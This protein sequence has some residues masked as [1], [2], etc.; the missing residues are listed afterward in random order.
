[1]LFLKRRSCKAGEGEGGHEGGCKESIEEGY[2]RYGEY[3]G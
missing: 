1:V 2:Q 3:H